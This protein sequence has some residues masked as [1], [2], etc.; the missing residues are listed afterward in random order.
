MGKIIDWL[1]GKKTDGQA[2]G[3]AIV[4]G[5]FAAGY[6]EPEVA[7]TLLSLLGAGIAVSLGKKI[8][9]NAGAK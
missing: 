4:V 9:R 5:L 2:V 1:K 8:E 3:V 6:I 7:G